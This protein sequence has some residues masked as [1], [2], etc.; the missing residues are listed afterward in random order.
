MVRLLHQP[1][2]RRNSRALLGSDDAERAKNLQTIKAWL[3]DGAWDLNRW[4]KRGDA[5]AVSKE[6]L[7]KIKAKC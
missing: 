1:F 2:Q 5:P 6:Q 7:D 4:E 3:G